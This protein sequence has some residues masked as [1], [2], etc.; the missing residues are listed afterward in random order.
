ML[1]FRQQR[2][3]AA[4]PKPP[5]ERNLI[6]VTKYSLFVGVIFSFLASLCHAQYADEES[7]VFLAE[8]K[9][10]D[11]NGAYASRESAAAF[12]QKFV[13][14]NADVSDEISD[15]PDGWMFLLLAECYRGGIVVEKDRTKGTQLL[16]VAAK[17]GNKNAAH[18][19]A[20][21]DV[22]QSG[23]PVRQSEGFK[24]LER[25]HT[26]TGSAYAAGK[27]GWAYQQG[28]GVAQDIER[29]LE[30]YN[31]AAERGMTYWQ[32]L[33]AHAYEMGYLGL[34]IDK[35]RSK[36]WLAFKPKVHVALY[37][38]WVA[39]YYRDGTF[40]KN[41]ELRAKHQKICDETDIA[42]VWER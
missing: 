23:D 36:Y 11:V 12:S 14:L 35:E 28:F 41:E 2:R 5:L 32:Y 9:L 15:L 7:C 37:E 29:A 25:E 24:Y 1:I 26:E 42:D 21:I 6:R 10:P 20:S 19:I 40:P 27:V 31:Y 38:C 3:A 39:I 33:L 18:M 4:D 8:L 13:E 16:R 17:Q 22:F 34:E 30:L